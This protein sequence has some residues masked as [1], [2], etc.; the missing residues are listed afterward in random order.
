MALI[1]LVQHAEKQRAAGDPGLTERG[2][3]Q[4]ECV[5]ARLRDLGIGA[6]Y[7][8]PLKRAQQTADV[9]GAATGLPV[10]VDERLSERMNW[11]PRQPIGEFIADWDRATNDRDFV[12]SSGNSS[13]QAGDRIRSF[14]AD[15]A[16]DAHAIAAVTHGGATVD[17]LR[18]VLGDEAVPAARWH[19]GMPSAGLTI[20][21]GST[22]TVI[23]ATDH[24]A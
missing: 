15:H 3:R 1:Y 2:H 6:I 22:V 18:T 16:R 11:D 12:P 23:G 9:I 7:T 5:A 4:A 17:F 21:D 19:E 24:L 20:L 13:R 8:S 10:V 14:V